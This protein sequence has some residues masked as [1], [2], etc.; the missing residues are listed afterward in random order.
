MKKSGASFIFSGEVLGQR[1]MSQNKS[2]LMAVEKLS[3]YKGLILRP[4][5]ALLLPVT[6]PEEKGWVD[7]T[8]LL[9]IS[10]RSRKIQIQL[11]QDYGIVDYPSPAGGCLLTNPGYSKRLKQYLDLFPAATPDEFSILLVGRHFYV[12]PHYLLVIGRNHTENERLLQIAET[13]DYLLKVKNRPGPQG[14]IRSG[15]MQDI[16]R[17]DLEN[18]AAMVARY[19]DAK[20]EELVPVKLFSLEQEMEDLFVTPNPH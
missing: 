4:L 15:N 8:K 14:L 9:G 10:G 2:S 13:G 16:T 7:R 12:S 6:I 3:G 11:A 19:S 18:S 20:D 17:N 1:P 5:S